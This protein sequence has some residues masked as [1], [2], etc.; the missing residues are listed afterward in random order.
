MKLEQSAIIKFLHFKKVKAVEI[1]RELALRFGNDAYT[2]PSV[3]DWVHEFKTD[4]ASVEDQ[5]P[6]GRAPLD[7][8]DATILKQLLEVPFFSLWTLSQSLEI[9]INCSIRYLIN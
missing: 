5:P 6:S 1:H 3:P 2:P 9:P 4:R 7:A 8:F